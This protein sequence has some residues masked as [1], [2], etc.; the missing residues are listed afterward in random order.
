[1][2][3]SENNNALVNAIPSYLRDDPSNAQYE[4]FVEMI[5]QHFDNVFSYLQ[6]VTEKYNA[7][8]R[9]NY[10]VSKDLV[11]DIL[12]D[13]G[14]KIYQNNFSTDD[15]Y[16]A[17]IGITPSGSLYNLPYTTPSL[18]APT[19]FEY[20]TTYITASATGS[21]Q[22][23]D[24]VNKSIYKRIYHNLPYL[25]KK[26]GTIEGLR[27]IITLYGIP[28]TILR[29]NEYGGKDKDNSNDWDYWYDQYNYAYTQN[30]NNFISSSWKLNSN[31][32]SPNG[33]PSTIAFRFK[34]NGLPT[35][36]IPISQSL[37]TISGSSGVATIILTYTGSGYTSASYSGSTVDPY[38]QYAKLDFI[39]RT[40]FLTTSASVYLPFFDGDWWSVMVTKD[41]SNFTLYSKN[42]IYNGYDGNQIGFQA[43]SSSTGNTQAWNDLLDL[44]VISYFGSASIS[45]YTNFSGSF[46][47]IRYY[48][49]II[50][51]SVFDDY[52]MNPNSIEGNG[53]NQGPNQLA[54]RA[55][56]GGE[57][58]TGSTSI[59]PK[60][61]GSWVATSSFTSDSN[62]TFNTTPVF[63]SNTQSVFF[64]QPPVGIKNPVAD[65]IKQQS[66][67][68][69]YSSSLANI[70]DNT[71][72]SN[73]RSIQQ[74]Y[75]IS[76]SY[77]RDV[78]Y[79]EVTFSPQNEI[80]DDIS[81]QI[82]FINIGE[83]IGDP[84]LV[85]SSAETYPPLDA[86]RN[87]YFEK[88]THNYDIN[89]YIRLI[90]FID[91]SLFKMLQDWTPARA[92]LASGIVV[93]QHLLE[94]NKYP[95]PQATPNTPIAYYGSGSGNIAWDTP[96]TFQNLVVS[97]AGIRMYEVTGSNAG[98][99][100]NLNG[101]TSSVILPGNYTAS[102][103]QV[104][105]GTTPSIVGP[106][107][108]TQSSQTEFF[109]GELS[110]SNLVVTNGDLNGDNPFLNV[111][112]TILAYT[113]SYY[114]DTLVPAGNFLNINTSPNNG[115]IYLLYDGTATFP[116][117]PSAPSNI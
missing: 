64:D 33:V 35:S 63:V 90:K 82:G 60:I 46:Q 105:S 23:V 84:R 116:S 114:D 99:F 88:Y 57:L 75:A 48:S 39:P 28:D 41:G 97:G 27:A 104:W 11:A 74:D 44:G 45:N 107:V 93:K 117:T 110:G 109:N 69:P 94:R 76:Q 80:D 115:E 1:L 18:P 54:F 49:T 20:I 16:A 31:W 61:T 68:L 34:T 77:T 67:S 70:P 38:Y 112:T 4:L 7:D 91:N 36:N 103:T 111:N 37:W 66:L 14:I 100:P 106:V 56:L 53:T 19:G 92:S 12:R 72:L 21:L 89:D 9:L 25:L 55:S 6:G 32:G 65:K 26:K 30:G 81:S 59:H 96:F 22:P 29:I 85:S 108:F 51:E 101:Q 83:Y 71:T 15:L 8:N 40:L 50:S 62:F 73:V 58:Y 95:V 10:G 13:L 98:V 86:L 5:G 3:D 78:N 2:Y 102:V 24:D 42:S 113:A 87:A 43:S 47:E 52:V 79:V 17:L